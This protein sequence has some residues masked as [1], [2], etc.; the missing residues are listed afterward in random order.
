LYFNGYL[1]YISREDFL[2]KAGLEVRIDRAVYRL[3]RDDEKI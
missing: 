3:H 1:E 2:R